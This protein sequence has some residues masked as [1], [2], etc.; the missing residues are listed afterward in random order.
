MI[1]RDEVLVYFNYRSDS[2]DFMKALNATI[3]YVNKKMGYAVL[4]VDD[5]NLSKIINKLKKMRGFKK[6]EVSPTDLV[7]LN[8]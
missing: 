3:V 6:Y 7:E 5:E 4:Y 1:K 8:V 2:L